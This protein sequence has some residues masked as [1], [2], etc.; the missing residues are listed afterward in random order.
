MYDNA[1]FLIAI[2]FAVLSTLFASGLLF[3][4][5]RINKKRVRQ[6]L[7]LSEWSKQRVEFFLLREVENTR[8]LLK[9]A[10]I[11]DETK[12]LAKLR[13]QWLSAELDALVDQG[14]SHSDR[15]ILKTAAKLMQHRLQKAEASRAIQKG[16][17]KTFSDRRAINDVRLIVSSSGATTGQTQADTHE[18]QLHDIE[19]TQRKNLA[20]LATMR[21]INS[22][23]RRLI[24]NLEQEL[25]NCQRTPTQQA[26]QRLPIAQLGLLLRDYD[27][28]VAMLELETENL[29]H[30]IGLLHQTTDSR[31]LCAI[32][33]AIAAVAPAHDMNTAGLLL[34]IARAESLEHAAAYLLGALQAANLETRIY[35]KGSHTQCW[36][37]SAAVTDARSKQLLQA[38]VPDIDQP[39]LEQ[40]NDFLALFSCC[41]IFISGAEL[42]SEQREQIRRWL[43]SILPLIDAVLVHVDQAQHTR[44]QHKH[45]ETK[46]L[47]LQRR[48]AAAESHQ[49]RLLAQYHDCADQLQQ[50]L[51]TTLRSIQPSAVQRQCI[52]AMLADF[53]AQVALISNLKNCIACADPNHPDQAE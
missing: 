17:T 7:T 51:A 23:Q 27:N 40:R 45:D 21:D 43:L 2:E 4:L 15:N 13:S 31:Q 50:E 48:L 46:L 14:A 47:M 30:R 28:C 25:S 44:A 32:P 33:N 39:W 3:F 11:D 38:L 52:D 41:R 18:T 1:L 8:L 26:E 37:A 6:Q 42:T 22:Q 36:T 20:Q 12:A 5:L 29:R 19:Q 10:S 24:L 9:H 49:R 53:R 34:K 35:L 16:M